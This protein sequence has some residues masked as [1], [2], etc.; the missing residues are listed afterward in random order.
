MKTFIVYD[1]DTGVPVA[2]GEAMKGEWARAEAAEETNVRA[3]DYI[4]GPHLCL[5]RRE[6]TFTMQPE[7]YSQIL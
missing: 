4:P 2:V 3:G 6:E 5:V 1:L 7:V